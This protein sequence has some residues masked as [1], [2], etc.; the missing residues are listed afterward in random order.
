MDIL[1]TILNDLDL[2][3]KIRLKCDFEIYSEMR[4]PEDQDGKVTWNIEGMAFGCDASGGEFVLLTD[5]SIGFNSSEGETGR[6]AENFKD[7]FSLLVN[8]PCFHD[9][10]VP[11]LYKDRDLL[12]KYGEALEREYKDD[13]NSYGT[14]DWDVL[15]EEMATALGLSIDPNISKN[16]MMDFYKAATRHPEYQYV[17]KEDDG[18]EILSDNLISRPLAPWIKEKAGMK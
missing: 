11:D 18:S 10:L 14:Y 4:K 5:G 9:F 13:F 2:A 8:C 7:F 16:T 12:E 3:E 15:K 17:Y 6:L 1:Q